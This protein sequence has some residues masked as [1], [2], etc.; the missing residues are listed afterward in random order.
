M[1]RGTTVNIGALVLAT[2]LGLGCAHSPPRFDPAARRTCLV[3]SAG[4]TR[5]VAHLGALAAVREARL[6][7]S[8][9]VGSS[10]GALIGSLYASAPERDTTERFRRVTRAYLAATEEAAEARGLKAGI[11]LATVA[12]TVAGGVLAPV[13]AALGGFVLGAVTTSRADLSRFEEVLRVEVGGVAIERLPVAFA[14]LHH[15]REGQ[16]LSL[17]I[18]R[19]GDLA[20]AVGASIANPFVFDDVEVARAAKI[21]PGGDRLAATPVQDACRLFPDANLLVVNLQPSPA[22]HDAQMKCPLLEVMVEVGDLPPEALFTDEVAF[23]AA[24]K[25][26][27]D[28]MTAALAAPPS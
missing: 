14:A 4:G 19:T 16:G 23:E 25:V 27:H 17:V 20:A 2:V 5:G 9:V 13:T 10:V 15:E 6:P 1:G 24:W 11:L 26:G 18:D 12:A 21:D 28:T 7:V 8:C 22:F 3:L